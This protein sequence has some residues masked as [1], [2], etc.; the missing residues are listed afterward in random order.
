MSPVTTRRVG[1]GR[2]EF[3]AEHRGGEFTERLPARG[4]RG[5]SVNADVVIGTETPRVGEETRRCRSSMPWA[6]GGIRRAR[7]LLVAAA[8]MI[9]ASMS[10]AANDGAPAQDL[11]EQVTS[12]ITE[13]LASRREAIQ[14]DPRALHELVDRLLLPYF[15]FERMSRRVLGS[16]RWKKATPEQQERFV[17]AFRTLLVN[18]YANALQ[19]YDGQTLTYLDPIARKKDDEIVI[20]V[21]VELA[22]GQPVR[23]AYAMHGTGTDWKVFDVA[24]DGVSLVK[25]Y[26]SSFRSEIA[27]HGIDGLIERLEAKN[28][29]TD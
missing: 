17:S 4:Q 11:V 27:R 14:D 22:D 9:A 7:A 24:I 5:P 18:T 12:N 29:T 2:S 23:V 6:G 8:A 15:D 20:P 10:L 21:Q 13:E 16:K 28:S 1:T 26:R 25:N 19:E 3:V